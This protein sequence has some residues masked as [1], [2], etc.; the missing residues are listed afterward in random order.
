MRVKM[1][2]MIAPCRN[3]EKLK[4]IQKSVRFHRARLCAMR[5]P[6]TNEV[7]IKMKSHFITLSQSASYTRSAAITAT[8]V[9]LIAM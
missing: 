3:N 5:Y 9:R 2:Q 8:N 4:N 7:K 6:K 1:A